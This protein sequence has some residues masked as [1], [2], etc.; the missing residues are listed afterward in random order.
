MVSSISKI[1]QRSYTIL[2]FQRLKRAPCLFHLLPAIS[3]LS[4][5]ALQQN[6]LTS[7]SMVLCPAYFIMPCRFIYIV[8]NKT[9]SFVLGLNHIPPCVCVIFLILS[10]FCNDTEG[11]ISFRYINFILFRCIHR[12]QIVRSQSSFTLSIFGQIPVLFIMDIPVYILTHSILS[13]LNSPTHVFY[14][15]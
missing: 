4:S 13:C 11:K 10:Q 5:L 6:H 8:D 1:L 14:S 15:H 7:A 9:F 3:T 12:N 2:S